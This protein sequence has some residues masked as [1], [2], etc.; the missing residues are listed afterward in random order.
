MPQDLTI[1][2]SRF[3][4]IVSLTHEHIIDCQKRRVS[5][6]CISR[7]DL[8][9]W[10]SENSQMKMN[11][12][13]VGVVTRRSSAWLA[14]LTRRRWANPYLATVIIIVVTCILKAIN[15]GCWEG[16]VMVHKC[17]LCMLIIS[18][19]NMHSHTCNWICTQHNTL[20]ALVRDDSFMCCSAT[21][22]FATAEV[23]L[24]KFR[25]CL[26]SAVC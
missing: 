23:F 5:F 20:H 11:G 14:G 13:R 22:D 15:H 18:L 6:T 16:G 1:Q 2:H 25:N 19:E 4:S 10:W 24:L 8:Q 3:L 21:F 12:R 7:L 9:Q 26:V 17:R